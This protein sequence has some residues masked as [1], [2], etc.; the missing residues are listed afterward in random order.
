VGGLSVKEMSPGGSNR[1]KFL[2]SLCHYW[3]EGPIRSFQPGP[4]KTHPG[5][6]ERIQGVSYCGNL[7]WFCSLGRAASMPQSD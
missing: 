7:Q 3:R 6:I 4:D 2:E 5:L 1:N